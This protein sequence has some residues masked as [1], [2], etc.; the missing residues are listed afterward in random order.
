MA[1][2]ASRGA[3]GASA[4]GDS[5]HTRSVLLP[6]TTEVLVEEAERLGDGG[7]YSS[8]QL[9]YATCRAVERPAVSVTRGFIGLGAL[10][11][12]LGGAMLWVKTIPLSAILAVI[13]V[14]MLLA[15]PLNARVEHNRELRRAIGSRAL[16]TSYPNFLAGP[17]AEALRVRPEAFTALVSPAPSAGDASD[18]PAAA[19][20]DA[21]PAFDHLAGQPASGPLVVC[22][23]RETAD[24][25]AANTGRLRDGTEVAALAALMTDDGGELGPAVRHRRLVAVHDADPAGCGLPAAL[26]RAGASDIAD[27]GLRPPASDAGL[28]VIEGAPARMPAGIEAD[29]TH[30]EVAWLRSGRRLELATLTP[31]E[32]VELVLTVH[33]PAL[34]ELPPSP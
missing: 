23:R 27:A 4:R 1:T 20:G 14:A 29:L 28:Q 8:R 22:D 32:V 3:D 17:L 16:A 10:L 18:S 24:L 15:A 9:Y 31:R 13:G 30:V 25:L 6:I 19:R 34:T 5:W 33:P 7:R 26:R 2:A 21:P 11:I 12:V